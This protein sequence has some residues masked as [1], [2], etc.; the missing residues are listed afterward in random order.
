MKYYKYIWLIVIISILPLTCKAY[1]YVNKNNA[2]GVEQGRKSIY[3]LYDLYEYF[4]PTPEEETGQNYVDN[5]CGV[6]TASP[7]E[8]IWP[9]G[10]DEVTI[11]NG[12]KFALGTP[13]TVNI[14]S[15]YGS[16]PENPE[17]HGA[18]D[19]APSADNGVVNVIASKEGEVIYSSKGMAQCPTGSYGDTC[20]G[21]YGNYVVIKHDKGLYTL[22][23][24]MYQ[25]TIT[26]KVGEK[27]SQGQVIGKVGSSGSSTGTHLHFEFTNSQLYGIQNKYNPLDYVDPKNPRGKSSSDNKSDEKSSNDEKENDSVSSNSDMCGDMP[28]KFVN[29]ISN[30]EGGDTD[31]D[32][33]VAVDIG[34]G[35]G[36]TIGHGLTSAVGYAFRKFGIDPDSISIGSKLKKDVVDK[37]YVYVLQQ[38]RKSLETDLKNAGINMNNNQILALVSGRYNG[39]QTFTNNVISSYKQNG[40]SY[41]VY[42]EFCNYVSDIYG[43]VYGGLIKRRKIEWMLYSSGISTDLDHQSDDGLTK[44]VGN[45]NIPSSE[46][47]NISKLLTQTAEGFNGKISYY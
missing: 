23:A 18:L 46:K 30:F 10:S 25:N 29:M 15:Y 8:F 19:I 32:Y 5:A 41:K 33:Y 14:T 20:G 2:E 36:W 38:E 22:Y 28:D 37:V 24:H 43:K 13:N 12:K 44:C 34:D 27:V 11:Q 39:G 4:F 3:Q 21:G 17:G 45:F 40:N 16:R 1:E 7:N 42:S 9:I 6:T 35:A 26:V 31:G 47:N